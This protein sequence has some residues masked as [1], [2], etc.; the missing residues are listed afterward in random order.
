MEIYTKK[1][2]MSSRFLERGYGVALDEAIEANVECPI[3]QD[4]FTD[5]PLSIYCLYGKNQL[6]KLISQYFDTEYLYNWVKSCK[7]KGK[8]PTN[9]N[10][11][12]EIDDRIFERIEK[13]YCIMM[14]IGDTSRSEGVKYLKDFK[15]DII[16]GK[17]IDE[18]LTNSHYLAVLDAQLF[19]N[20][21]IE[22]SKEV[23]DNSSEYKT[24]EDLCNSS[25]EIAYKI[26]EKCEVGS[27]LI[28]PTSVKGDDYNIAIVITK[29]ESK[30]DGNNLYK[31][32]LCCQKRGLGIVEYSTTVYREEDIT[33]RKDFNI[34]CD[35]FIELF[36]KENKGI[37]FDFRNY[38]FL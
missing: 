35:L 10:T 8:K 31:H 11:R 36:S 28:R 16:S 27:W 6:G 14:D 15:N 2:K 9:P 1:V 30:D 7:D 13:Y 17:E 26:L 37:E 20:D 25:R 5:K 23:V 22:H 3:S 4:V 19:K 33:N 32:I 29:L 12:E 24:D 18:V 21:F 34:L 38:V